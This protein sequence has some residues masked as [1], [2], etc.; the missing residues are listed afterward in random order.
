MPINAKYRV[1]LTEHERGWGR[2]DAGYE[3]FDSHEKAEKFQQNFN[4]DNTAN[5]VP[6]WYMVAEDPKLVEVS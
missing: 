3:D 1:R 2:R 4:A 6:D 5:I